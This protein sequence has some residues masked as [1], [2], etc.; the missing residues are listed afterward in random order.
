MSIADFFTETV[1]EFFKD[2]FGGDPV[3]QFQQDLA[4]RELARGKTPDQVVRTLMREYKAT[5]E[6]AERVVQ[7]TIHGDKARPA[8]AVQKSGKPKGSGSGQTGTDLDDFTNF[9]DQQAKSGE[10]AGDIPKELSDA[11]AQL[12]TTETGITP[13]QQ[14]RAKMIVDEMRVQVRPVTSAGGSADLVLPQEGPKEGTLQ[15]SPKLRDYIDR[16]Y[17]AG[18]LTAAEK[19]LIEHYG[20]EAYVDEIEAAGAEMIHDANNAGY[21]RGPEINTFL[22]RRAEQGFLDETKAPYQAPPFQPTPTADVARGLEDDFMSAQGSTGTRARREAIAR[23]YRGE[24]KGAYDRAVAVDRNQYENENAS[25]GTVEK[26]RDPSTF[27]ED[28]ILNSDEAKSYHMASLVFN[29]LK[30]LSGGL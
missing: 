20:P 23:D 21:M 7:E 6:Q 1:P 25:G 18:Y 8:A 22:N 27:A 19:R 3:E 2:A 24:E 4:R 30:A 9:A 10:T 12:Q 26:A 11:L 29:V 28:R 17:R 5:Q 13:A 14:K 16:L 15:D